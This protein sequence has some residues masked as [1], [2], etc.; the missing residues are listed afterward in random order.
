MDSDWPGWLANRAAAPHWRRIG[1]GKRFGLCTPLASVRSARGCGVGDVEDLRAVVDWA[2]EVGASLV[3]VLPL[4]DMGSG[5]VPY[6]AISAFALDPIYIALDRLDAVRDD[7]VLMRRLQGSTAHLNRSSFVDFEAVR[8]EKGAI[9]GEVWRRMRGPALQAE[10]E[11]FQAENP[12]VVPYAL[13]R[14]IRELEGLR[15]WEEW[16]ERYR[17]RE[18]AQVFRERAEDLERVVFAQWVLDRQF[19]E[20]RAYAQSRGVFLIGDI[21]I[22]VGRDSADVWW[23]PGLFR[24]DGSAGAPPDMYAAE[25]QNWGFPTYDWPR[26]RESGFAWW[27]ARLRHAER[28]FDLYRIDH[29]VG[30]FRIWTIPLGERT[31]MRGRFV[32]ED[33]REWGPQGRE[34]LEMM[35]G[36]TLMLPL[37]E[38]LGTIPPI[39]RETL[40]DLG[41]CGLKIQRWER[42]WDG[43]GRFIAPKDYEP[44][45]VAMLSTHDSETFAGWWEAFP[46]D[47]QRLY[48]AVGFDGAAPPRLDRD[49]HAH[50][51][52][53]FSHAGSVF[54]ILMVQDVLAPLGSLP[55]D[56]SSHRINVPGVVNDTNWRWRWPVEVGRLIEDREGVERLRDW[57]GPERRA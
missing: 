20:V 48:E 17:E 46:E 32:P 13:F 14:V 5:W 33:E 53:W 12:W 29:V 57:I 43:D 21:P 7:A 8:R 15:S 34:I 1:F 24:L 45:S 35:L 30:F 11:R 22:L 41:I 10:L 51:V 4:H 9:L 28:Y 31:G 44:L 16:G 19:R 18:R 52:R 39:C 23:E 47:R 55:G 27:R 49:L 37:A 26:H 56:P 40:R 3:Q 36:S 38:D 2:A 50:F 54:L 25:G 42:D 6:A